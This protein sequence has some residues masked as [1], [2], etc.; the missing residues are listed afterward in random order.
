M[1]LFPDLEKIWFAATY[2]GGTQVPPE[3]AGASSIFEVTRSRTRSRFT[4]VAP[5]PCSARYRGTSPKEQIGTNIFDEAEEV[6]VWLKPKPYLG[7]TQSRPRPVESTVL[8]GDCR[9]CE[10]TRRSLDC[11]PSNDRETISIVCTVSMS[12]MDLHF[13]SQIVETISWRDRP[14]TEH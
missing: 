1:T 14:S 11:V 8:R 4:H 7:W 6:P 13:P 9:R 2:G 3:A 10:G 5:R 12:Q